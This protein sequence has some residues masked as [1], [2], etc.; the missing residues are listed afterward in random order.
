MYRRFLNNNDYLGVITADALSQMTRGNDDRFI[1]SEEV[2]EMSIVEYLSENYEVEQELNKGKYIAGYDRKITYPVGAHI[3]H[4]GRICEVIR[5]IS[6]YKS[7]TPYEYWEEYTETELDNT[8]FYSQFDTY[9]KGDKVLYNEI[10]YICLHENG[11]KFGDIRIPL[12]LGWL[13]AIYEEWQPVRYNLWDI[14][15]YEGSFYTLISHEEFDNNQTPFE[16]KNWGAIAD[17]DQN[18]NEYE[19]NEHEYVVFEEKVFYPELDPNADIPEV[20]RNLSVNDPRNFNLK[21][22]MVRLAMYE[23]CKLIAANNISI[24]RIK[25]YEISMKWLSDAAKLK[26]NPQ[27]PRKLSEDKRPVMDWQLS[28]FQTNY[29]PYRNPWLV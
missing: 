1:Q 13:E 7:P 5:A 24:V 25:D 28:T 10:A 6:S 18:Y 8:K 15:L 16:S 3:Y 4:K 20:G 29:D 9:Y 27:I 11:Y 19:L 2:A 23:L 14:V 22:H 21:K 17:Y 26:L 12:V